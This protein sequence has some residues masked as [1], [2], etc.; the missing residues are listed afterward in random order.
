M[1]TQ[2]EVCTKPSADS[3]EIEP[4]RDPRDDAARFTFTR[5]LHLRAP[6]QK[7]IHLPA[8]YPVKHV[9]LLSYDYRDYLPLYASNVPPCVT[10]SLRDN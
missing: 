5:P 9:A 4:R 2:A 6:R 7:T 10:F 3:T 1:P 8:R